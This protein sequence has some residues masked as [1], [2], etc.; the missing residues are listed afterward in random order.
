MTRREAIA[1]AATGF[2][3]SPTLSALA[4][5]TQRRFRIGACDW[6]IGRRGQPSALALAREIGLDGVQVSFGDPDV[7]FDLRKEDV[8]RQY[9]QAAREHSVQIASLGMGV[10]N[11]VPYSSSL[12]AERWVEQCIEVLPRLNQKIVLLAFFGQGD[13][14]DKPD[15]QAEV[16]RRLK[17]VAPKAEQ[18][19]VILGL[20]TWLSADE[21]LR[22]LDAVGSPSVQVYYDTANMEKQGYDIYKEIRQLGRERICEF[23][24]KENGFLLGEGRVDFRRVKEA[25]DDIGY[26][27]WL[28][29]ESAVGKGRS[30]QDS[31]VHNQKYLRSVYQ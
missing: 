5:D 4:A 14:K 31:Y 8:R 1:A 10:L 11:S 30:I 29:I 25:M 18:A 26:D 7:Q 2:V 6:S 12:D 24:C 9:Q 15:L 17:K 13:I 16:I 28:V 23:H 19:G 20:E 3:L 21:H 27:G 22:I